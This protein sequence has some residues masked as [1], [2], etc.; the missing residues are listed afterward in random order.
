M[1]WDQQRYRREVLD[2]ARRSGP[3]A[4]LFVRYGFRGGLP[5]GT[6]FRT[7]VAE[8]VGLWKSLRSKPGWGKLIDGLLAQHTELER[9]QELTP[10]AFQARRQRQQAEVSQRLAALISGEN[11]SHVGPATLARLRDAAGAGEDQVRQ[12]LTAAGITVVDRLPDL[13]LSPPRGY[14]QLGPELQIL[15][16][17]VSAEVVFGT[18]TVR[19]GFR[20][21]GGF[22]LADGRRMT[23]RILE[24]A[25]RNASALPHT[26][27]RKTPTEALLAVL[28][29]A[30]R[31]GRLDELLL[32]E[33]IGPLRKDVVAGFGQK[34]IANQAKVIGLNPEE[35]GVL[36]VALL[37]Q[38]NGTN[39][40]LQIEDDLATGR[41]RSAQA[42]AASLPRD[43]ELRL[44]VE[45][46]AGELAAL[47]A[48]AES[49]LSA[50]RT[51]AAARLFGEA[52][53]ITDDEEPAERLARIPPPAPLAPAA[54][55]EQDRILV[56]WRASPAQAGHLRYLVSRGEGRTP[57]S[58]AEGV[59]VAS[60][61]TELYVTDADAPRGAD[62]RYAVFAGRGGWQWSPPA[63]A[64]P[65]IFA[66]DVT[67]AALD[68]TA[69]AVGVVWRPAPGA[70]EVQVVRVTDGREATVESGMTGFSD[71]GL[72]AGQEYLYR[73]TAVYRA[74][75][76]TLRYSPG[77][78]I[79]VIP[80]PTPVPVEVIDVQMDG[81]VLRLSWTPPPLG[82]V[83]LILS[84]TKPPWP[85]GTEPAPSELAGYG[86]PVP[87]SPRPAGPGRVGVEIP[88]PSGRHY[89]L[90]L[91]WVGPRAV[92][93]ARAELGLAEP[94]RG[95]EAQR[96][97]DEAQLSWIWPAGAVNAIITWPSGERRCSRRVYEDEGGV[98]IPV[99]PGEAI[100][101]VSTVHPDPAG[102]LVAAA[103]PVTVPARA[104]EVRYRWR[105]GFPM[106]P[107]RRLLE[108]TADRA[109]E[110]P[111]L[112]V[113]HSRAA[114]PP[115]EPD[116]GTELIRLP[117]ASIS[118]AS[119]LRIPVPV[120]RGVKGYLACFTVPGRDTS[121]Q[122]FP[123]PPGEM[124][125][126]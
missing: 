42:R 9:G 99:G 79:R 87:S 38:G 70:S 37:G 25:A 68:V 64:D 113:V 6:A 94:C 43:D 49:E 20:V 119:P 105:K 67:D 54:A 53:R 32:W 126:P 4:D 2:P 97:L 23:D 117:A 90:A 106:R 89:L 5:S 1:A 19:K 12:A 103:V 45:T 96:L 77:V 100:V 115:G 125:I 40:R 116:E 33:V 41:L 36:S 93:G 17:K 50:G 52:T 118:P 91:T 48:R 123:P 102:E 56:S 86:R 65:V 98:R 18:E 24:D 61:I 121:V 122:L 83:D 62:L 57:R 35:A 95:L 80:A 69:D 16:L 58:P 71:T 76:G 46:R 112:V 114:F 88:P 101:R 47:L 63:A 55:V 8:V 78:T 14:P 13:P 92:A 31:E 7:Q 44:M 124:R 28:K 72:T 104:T 60:E 73:I 39:L 85:P 3:P 111:E 74:V 30:E 108:L 75:D 29:S 10:A 59:T 51:E 26:D 21:I 22:R 11:A 34:G 110:L 109:C 66:P 81:D 107:G 120:P 27:A 84:Q 15:G 82:R